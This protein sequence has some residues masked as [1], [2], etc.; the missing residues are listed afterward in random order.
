[1]N[2]IREAQKTIN[3]Y[4]DVS[5]AEM[6]ENTDPKNPLT[7]LFD[8]FFGWVNDSLDSRYVT[9]DDQRAKMLE[10][11]PDL[12]ITNLSDGFDLEVA[13]LNAIQQKSSRGFTIIDINPALLIP[14]QYGINIPYEFLFDGTNYIPDQDGSITKNFRSI[15]IDIAGNFVKVE[16]IYENNSTANTALYNQRPYANIKY[17][18]ALKSGTENDLETGYLSYYFDN[19]ARNK[20][21]IGFGDNVQKPHIVTKSGDYFETYFNALNITVNIGCPKIRI[22]VGFNSK[23]FD[24][25]SNDAINSQLHLLGSGRLFSQIDTPLVPMNVGVSDTFL[26]TS[27]TGINLNTGPG[28]TTFDV[29]LARAFGDI[30][31]S[32]SVSFGYSVLFITDLIL[33]S[34][35]AG[36]ITYNLC[37]ELVVRNPIG[38]EIRLFKLPTST[39]P[40]GATTASQSRS[41]PFTSPLRVVIPYNSNLVARIIFNSS[42]V[43]TFDY[44]M[45]IQGYS[46]GSLRKINR[47]IN[48]DILTSKFITDSTFLT[49]FNRTE[50]VKD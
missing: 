35:F 12:D 49:D 21:F 5:W 50:V 9:L 46:L 8:N 10:E 27:T 3:N 23:K 41:I 20:V 31:A 7:N 17:Q 32:N 26:G 36:T 11:N 38:N 45:I 40:S 29:T 47:T 1:M 42:G 44:D 33:F 15:P 28:V 37:F 6:Y 2:E 16:Y 24:G 43:S 18:Q 48:N 22:T 19:F 14:D 25:P 30:N 13:R 4:E 34:N 39:T